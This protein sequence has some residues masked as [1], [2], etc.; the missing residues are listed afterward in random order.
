MRTQLF[1]GPGRSVGLAAS[2]LA[3]VAGAACGG[4]DSSDALDGVDA[5]VFIQ[6]AK[7]NETGDIFQYTSYMPGGRI[8]K[9]SPPTAD[10]QL[11]V[12][13]C[14]NAGSEFADIDISS[15]DL[16]FDA[17]EIVFSGK[18]RSDD[19]YGLFILR[20]EDNS[21]EQLASDPSRDYVSP[22]FLP[23]D[24]I[25]FTT[26]AVVE[27]GAP[28]HR[29]E[30]ERGTTLQVGVMNRDGTGERLGARNLS[31]RVFPTLASDGRVVLTQWDHLGPQN[32]GHL[33][34][35]NPDMTQLR[36]AFGKEGT[37]VANSY[38]KATEI[39][40]GR[41]A[42]IASSR[43]RT[44]QA[45]A[46]IDIRF[47]LTSTAD[48]VVRADEKMSEANATYRILTPNVPLDRVP[49][50]ST[51]GRYY[52]VAALDAGE[53]PNLLVSWADGPVESETLAAAGLSAD[54][55][56]YLYDSKNQVR[57]P[58]WNDEALW[59]VFPK[60]LRPRT[61]P[62][63]IA[64]SA[65]NEF[66]DTAAL[67]GSLDAYQSTIAPNLPEGAVYG[68]RVMEGFSSEEGFPMDFGTTMH[69]GHAQL[70]VAPLADDDSWAAL[71]PANVPVH[72]QL[73][74]KFGMSLV[75]EPVWQAAGPGEARMCGG[76]HEDRAESTIIQPGQVQALLDG[77][78]PM[79]QDTPR[80]Q[81]VSTGYT[82]DEVRGVPWDGAVQ[83]ALTAKCAGC[84]NGDPAGPNPTYTITDPETGASASWTFNLTGEPVNM[85]VGEFIIDGYSASYLSL[86][87]LD[88]EEI[89][90]ANVEVTG[91]Y[92]KYMEPMAAAT[93]PLFT[94]LNPP[95]QFPTQDAGERAFDGPTHADLAGFE[96]LTPDE[97]YLLILSNEMGAN[98]YSR[99]NAPLDAYEN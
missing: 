44:V 21:V 5:I 25:M 55:G 49:S 28:Q 15:Y 84:H 67:I 29:D 54:F 63:V 19:T 11:T 92:T 89:D 61:A 36:E 41:F 79:L 3:T 2:L 37:G 46:L 57:R 64:P 39:A 85:A 88:E 31:H 4:D 22:I 65:T 43:D 13:C 78:V 12:L 42:A 26:N 17:R 71:V 47:G 56:V 6:R 53:Y 70:G 83:A 99:E 7:R 93:A 8:V 45:G 52:D 72:V 23:G 48:G 27:E 62:P 33:M 68:V 32:A 20:L 38:L 98:F 91:D 76:C 34:F 69:E 51:V 80:Q 18:L 66:S 87:G 97:Y 75:N 96:D 10:G 50:S 1:R 77:P 95:Q 30:Y 35:M 74:D 14:D 40:P 60:A 58:I 86:A 9:L 82:R 81:R 94:L 73:I 90:M 16:S 59:D 24:K